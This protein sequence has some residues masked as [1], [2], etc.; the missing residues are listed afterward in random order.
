MSSYQSLPESP[1]N[2]L[3]R[4]PVVWDETRYVAGIPGTYVVIAR[5]KGND[6]YIGGINGENRDQE[7]TFDLPFL[8]NETVLEIITDGGEPA[9]FSTAKLKT[10]GRGI[11]VKLQPRGGFVGSFK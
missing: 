3:K 8:A 5:R 11:K 2:F 4:V 7:I 6:W 10:N 9:T 1:K